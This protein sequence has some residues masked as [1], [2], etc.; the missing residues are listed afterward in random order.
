[1]TRQNS[2]FWILICS[3]LCLSINSWSYPEF[4]GYGYSSCLTCHYNGL[5]GGPLNDYGR[6][7][8]SAEISSRALYPYSM[9]DEEI[10]NQSG[11]LGSIKM[12]SWLRPHI[13]YRG[14]NLWLSPGGTNSDTKFFQ[15]QTDAGLTIQA[16]EEGRFLGTA[17]WGRVIN[18][19]NFGKAQPELKPIHAREYYIRMEI[20]KSWWLYV[21]LMEKVF[22][23]RNIDHTSFQ[24]SF[25]GFNIQNDTPDGI[26]QSQGLIM[27]KIEDHWDLA[28]NYFMGNPYDRS[29]FKQ[30]GLSAMGEYEVSEK[31]RLGASLMTVKNDILQKDLVAIHFRQGLS[32]GS[33]FM[34][35][36]GLLRKPSVGDQTTGSYGLLQTLLELSRGYN[37]TTTVEH[38]NQEFKSSSPDFWKVSA[39]ILAFPLPRLE[40]RA[41][42]VNEREISRQRSQDDSWEVQGQ[43][44]VS[45]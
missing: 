36:L 20:Q 6:A 25:Q 9:S 23:I 13:N 17:T 12:P 32:K 10:A 5:G 31:M 40:L 29:T 35:E 7:L 26:S 43:I 4:I 28:V 18:P 1:M 16:D 33:A 41:S 15:M 3:V 8:W 34:T 37:L 21:G 14:L 30:T 45:L 39:G 42:I 27:Q 11:F 22:G 2:L 19:S 44:H 38:Y 24:R